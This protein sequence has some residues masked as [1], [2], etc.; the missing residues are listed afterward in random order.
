MLP[1]DEMET[2]TQL[3]LDLIAMASPWTQRGPSMRFDGAGRM[4]LEG[5]PRTMDGGPEIPL[6]PLAKEY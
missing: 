3:T 6:A 1:V 4:K 2:Q 5:R